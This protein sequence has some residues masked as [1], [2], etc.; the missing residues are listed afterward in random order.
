MSA[1]PDAFNFVRGAAYR[2]VSGN[3]KD[4]QKLSEHC[5]KTLAEWR[6]TEGA[7]SGLT[8]ADAAQIVRAVTQWTLQN[9]RP[10]RQRAKR[11]REE[12]AATEIS[13]PLLLEFAE[14][15]YGK[16]TVRNAAR[17]SGQ[18]KSTIARTCAIA[19]CLRNVLN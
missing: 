14:E 7:G 3:G 19:G 18:S 15:A 4:S 10:P 5:V 13:S 1:N 6:R 9:Y 12:R 16:G 11:N 17:I 8:D 2:F